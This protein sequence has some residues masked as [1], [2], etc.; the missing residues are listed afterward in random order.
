MDDSV[1]I[2]DLN[3]LDDVDRAAIEFSS[4]DSGGWVSVG[5]SR[6]A[7]GGGGGGCFSGLSAA[8]VVSPAPVERGGMD[9][10][11]SNE[12]ED[13]KEGKGEEDEDEEEQGEG[14]EE[15][16]W[17]RVAVTAGTAVGG[18]PRGC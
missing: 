13:K 8:S 3:G 18:P 14:G 10:S 6:G 9:L 16:T 2:S 4:P 7:G 12:E 11:D 1:D 5:L 15:D 17:D